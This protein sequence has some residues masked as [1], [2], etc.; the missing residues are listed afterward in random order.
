VGRQGL[1]APGEIVTSPG[2]EGETPTLGGTSVEVPFVT[3]TVA[4][5]WSMVPIVSA[6]EVK[7]AVIMSAYGWQRTKYVPPLLD[8]WASFQM[9]AT[10]YI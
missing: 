4:L 1:I 3:G 7:S 2:T 10:T 5:M 8:A 9:M 6:D